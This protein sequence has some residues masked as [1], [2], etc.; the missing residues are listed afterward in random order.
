MSKDILAHRAAEIL[1]GL[2]T[3]NLAVTADEI[4]ALLKAGLA[5]EADPVHL[6]ALGRMAALREEFSEYFHGDPFEM[7]SFEGALADIDHKLKSEWYRLRTA[8]ERIREHE[9]S[10]VQLRRAIGLLHDPE[11]VDA[12]RKIMAESALLTRDTKYVACPAL[13]VELYAITAK[14]RAVLV[15]LRIRMQ[16]I[17]AAPLSAFLKSFDKAHSKM[18]AFSQNIGFLRQNIGPVRKR[19][20]QVVIGLVKSGLAPNVA[21]QTY[22]Q[23]LHQTRTPDVAVLCTRNAPTSGGPALVHHR[24]QTAM[25][26]LHRAGFPNTVEANG[27]AKSLLSYSPI[28]AGVPRFVELYRRL[29]PVFGDRDVVYKFIVRLMPASGS[30]S[31][32]VRRVTTT[33]Q[34]L[35]TMPSRVTHHPDIAATAVAIAGMVKNDQALPAAVQRHRELEVELVR[36]GVTDPMRAEA[37]A[38]E[39]LACPGTPLEVASVVRS[40]AMNLEPGVRPS[41]GTSAIAV[42]FAKRFAY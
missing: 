25:E 32:I 20:E 3:L 21:L 16:R 39:C 14:G 18:Q 9:A 36:A 24:L 19:P 29:R 31:E 26:A 30:P 17:G 8:R 37:H 1:H 12:F 22:H 4:E 33:G 34:L 11:S 42:S 28:E 7:A 2:E 38:L 6:A 27:A 15:E 13:G 35:R 5:V 41:P 23:A 40:L 10:R